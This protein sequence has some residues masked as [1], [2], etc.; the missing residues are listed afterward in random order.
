VLQPS[1]EPKQYADGTQLDL[2]ATPVSSLRGRVP[3]AV[4]L[5]DPDGHLARPYR[6]VVLSAT[7]ADV[8][9]WTLLGWSALADAAKYLR[10]RSVW[11]ALSRL[12]EARG[13]ALRLWAVDQGVAYPLFGLTSLLDD[14]GASLP[15]GLDATAARADWDELRRAVV[16]CAELLDRAAGAA[17]A[18]LGSGE[19]TPMAAYVQGRLAAIAPPP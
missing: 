18:A 14:P 1:L 15:A 19:P 10:R 17:R 2:V 3:D 9:E 16:A 11:E 4:V 7:A 6:P 5:H 12:E 8:R 13:L